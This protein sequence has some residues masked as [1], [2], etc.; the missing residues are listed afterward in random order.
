MLSRQF[1][2]S[3]QLQYYTGI[4]GNVSSFN[5]KLEDNRWDHKSGHIEPILEL[6]QQNLIDAEN[7]SGYQARHCHS[8]HLLQPSCQLGLQ[9]FLENKPKYDFSSISRTHLLS[10]KNQFNSIIL[11]ILDWSCLHSVCVRRESGY[12]GIEWGTAR[13]T[14][15]FKKHGPKSTTTK[16]EEY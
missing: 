3:E 9:V 4:S 11:T 14:F 7:L 12:C 16:N 10:P 8:H 1:L 6:F 5:W 15:F 2:M 13:W